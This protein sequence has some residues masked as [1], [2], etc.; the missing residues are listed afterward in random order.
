MTMSDFRTEDDMDLGAMFEAGR[1]HAPRPSDSLLARIEA[2]ALTEQA[3]FQEPRRAVP[4][5][6]GLRSLFPA[7]GGWPGFA[8][9]AASLVI[10][11]GIGFWQPTE[12]GLGTTLAGSDAFDE[13]LFF[14]FEDALAE[15]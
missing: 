2:E 1:R 12:L 7:F 15:G 4:V 8:G 5:R 3:E 10:G 6:S 9:L 14:N 11:I 13:E